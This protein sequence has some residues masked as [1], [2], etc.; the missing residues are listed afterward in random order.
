MGVNVA[1]IGQNV[2]ETRIREAAL[3]APSLSS[4]IAS[5]V[6]AH[7]PQQLPTYLTLEQ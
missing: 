1:V 4:R 3:A 6:D 2:P 7:A 5:A